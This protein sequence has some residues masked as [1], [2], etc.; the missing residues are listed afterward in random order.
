VLRPNWR[1]LGTELDEK[2]Y[3]YAKR[4]ILANDLDMRVKLLRVSGP[5][6]FPPLD[7]LGIE[8]ADFTM[9]NPPFYT[10][11]E[12]MHNTWNKSE[13]PSAACTGAEVEMIT[14]GGDV[15]FVL[16]MIKESRSLST[17]VQ[18]YTSML[19]KLSSARVIVSKLKEIKCTNWAVATLNAGGKTRRW[20]V[21]WSWRDRRPMNVS[22]VNCLHF[23]LNPSSICECLSGDIAIWREVLGP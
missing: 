12:D 20:V 13:P 17:R 7:D 21:G 22:S 18:W 16:R 14:Q 8:T 23:S 6:I 11:K 1:F 10:S 4:N 3:E 9:C 5:E 15:G 2:N 19:G